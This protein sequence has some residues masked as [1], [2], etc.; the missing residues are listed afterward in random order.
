MSNSLMSFLNF[1]TRPTR[2]DILSTVLGRPGV[3]VLDV[4]C[5][6]HS[7]RQFK[8]YFHHIRYF[9]LDREDYNID[10]RDTGLMEKYYRVDIERD[11]LSA[12]PDRSFDVIVLNHVIEHL[13]KGEQVVERLLNKL[14]DGG[15]MYI[16]F[17]SEHS[18]RLPHMK[19]TLNFYD[20]ETHVRLYKLGDLK[21]LLLKNNMKIIKAGIRSSLKGILLTP[22]NVLHALIK[23]RH[24]EGG[25]VWDITGFASFILAQKAGARYG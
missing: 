9:G 13:Q 7:A 25:D 15:Y 16:E 21:G 10:D 3:R 8:S 23:Y 12:I 5:G 1:V 18:V 24:V 4:G 2:F 6:N 17:P 20:D 14:A 19:G 11:D 22:L